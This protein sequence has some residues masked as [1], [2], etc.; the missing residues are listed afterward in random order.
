M[1]DSSN[2]ESSSRFSSK[3]KGEKQ[4]ANESSSSS[5]LT[6]ENSTECDEE[7]SGS[8]S[9]NTSKEETKDETGDKI[10]KNISKRSTISKPIAR[11]KSSARTRAESN[12]KKSRTHPATISVPRATRS[13]AMK[14]RSGKKKLNEESIKKATGNTKVKKVKMYEGNA[15]E[16]TVN[17]VMHD[18][19]LSKFTLDRLYTLSEKEDEKNIFEMYTMEIISEDQTP[20]TI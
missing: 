7:S 20:K 1:D 10:S 9:S 11:R 15:N 17:T 13:Q 3:K 14:L 12:A 19:E 6:N 18:F 8:N 16:D 5:D 4:D 2:S